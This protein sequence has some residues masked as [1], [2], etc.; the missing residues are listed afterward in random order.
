MT[1]FLDEACVAGLVTLDDALEAVEK[2]F[3]EAGNGGVTNVPRVRAALGGP[4]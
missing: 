1:L 2:V 4:C 3:R